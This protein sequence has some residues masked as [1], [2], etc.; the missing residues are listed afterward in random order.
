MQAS[1]VPR[2]SKSLAPILMTGAALM[3]GGA[4][5]WTAIVWLAMRIWN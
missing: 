5:A 3:A 4:V 2:R 1:R